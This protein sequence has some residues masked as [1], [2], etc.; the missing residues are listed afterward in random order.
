MRPDT[1][2]EVLAKLPTGVQEGRRRHRRQRQRHRRRRGGAGD[3]RR[4]RGEG[5]AAS[6]PLGRIV[7]W[8]T[9]GVE[10]T[11]MG[12]GPGAGDPQGAREAR[13]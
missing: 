8:A 5:A 7:S 3:R 6:K 9:V 4:G 1:T 11:M 2:M 10:P 13:S 12:M